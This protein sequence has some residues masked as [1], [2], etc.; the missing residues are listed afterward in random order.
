MVSP[1]DPFWTFDF[2]DA[3]FD[4]DDDDMESSAW[5]KII[6][7]RKNLEGR[8]I[9]V[10]CH[11]YHKCLYLQYKNWYMKLYHYNTNDLQFS[12]YNSSLLC[13]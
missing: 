9:K 11:T 6:E 10:Q 13:T 4:S 3:Y 12:Q 7:H 8:F 5:G 1:N 2:D